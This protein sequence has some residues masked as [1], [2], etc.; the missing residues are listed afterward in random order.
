MPPNPVLTWTIS[1]CASGPA[2][3]EVAGTVTNHGP[4]I[5]DSPTVMV[6]VDDTS[7]VLLG[8]FQAGYNGGVTGALALLG[9]DAPVAVGQT[10]AWNG[11]DRFLNPP[12][13]FM[14]RLITQ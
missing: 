9:G 11:G 5:S 14:C 8:Q 13:P 7:G 12:T 1:E 4:G 3:V 6:H 10:A 2:G